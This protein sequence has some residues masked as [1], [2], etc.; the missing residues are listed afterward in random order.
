MESMTIHNIKHSLIA[1][2]INKAFNLYFLYLS[3]IKKNYK[4]FQKYKIVIIYIT[5]NKEAVCI[6]FRRI[7]SLDFGGDS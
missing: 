7:H 5:S 4:I 2:I 6:T 3:N 1:K